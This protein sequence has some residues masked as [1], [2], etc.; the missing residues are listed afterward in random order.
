M[1]R[2]GIDTRSRLDARLRDLPQMIAFG[3][4]GDV[5]E[6]TEAERTS[7]RTLALAADSEIAL[8]RSSG[9]M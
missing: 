6:W 4:R 7:L 5:R 2:F 3:A 9:L 1:Q 8:R